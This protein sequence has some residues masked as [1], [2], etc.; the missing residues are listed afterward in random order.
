[1]KIENNYQ[2]SLVSSL[3]S[4]TYLW[5]FIK[6]NCS[7]CWVVPAPAK[8]TLLRMLAG[9]EA[10][11]SGRILIDGVDMAG[12]QPWKRPVNMMFQSYA[13]F[14]HLTVADNVAFGSEA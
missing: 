5:I 8:S 3:Q 2:E 1:M 6:A 12:I 13:L 7:A 4:I 11:T 10:P 14:P 9:F